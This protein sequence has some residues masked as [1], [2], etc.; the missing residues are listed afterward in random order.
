MREDENILFQSIEYLFRVLNLSWSSLLNITQGIH[1]EGQPKNTLRT[2]VK[3]GRALVTEC[4]DIKNVPRIMSVTHVFD[5]PVFLIYRAIIIRDGS[6]CSVN[7]H[8]GKKRSYPMLPG[9]ML[10]SV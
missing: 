1:Q 8:E 4:K 5:R 7:D 9:K 10:G 3:N 6:Y 2:I